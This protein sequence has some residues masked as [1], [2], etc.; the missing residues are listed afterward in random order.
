MY[1]S[2]LLALLLASVAAAVP[3]ASAQIP[4]QPVAQTAQVYE[5]LGVSVAGTEDEN[6]RRF[7]LQVSGL[8]VG[9]QVQLP[10]DDSV[11]E[12]V[13]KLYQ[14]GSFSNIEV[15]AENIVGNGI[16]LLIRVE[17]QPRLGS[18]RF[19]GIKRGQRD[20]LEDLVPLLR[21]RPVR[22]VDVAR[23]EQVIRNYFRDEGYLLVDI[24]VEQSMGENGRAD[25]VYTIDRGRKV[26]VENIRFVGNEAF[27]DRTL[28]KRLKNTPENRWWRFWGGESFVAREFEDDLEALVNWYQDEGYYGARVVQD[29]VWVVGEEEG[30]PEVNIRINV[31]EGPQYVV[32]N[33]T[34]EGNTEYTDAQLRAALGFEKG[35]VYSKK[36]FEQN[37]YYNPDHSDVASL[38]TDRGYLR[39][40][41][42]PT[43]TEAPGDSLDMAFLINEGDVYEFGQITIAG[44]TKTKEH[45]IRREL[46]TIPGQTYSRQA[47]ERSVRELITLNYFA[48][49][50]LAGGPAI[51]ID[52]DSKT[53]GLTYKLTEA[54]GDQLELS[55]GWGGFTGLL[56]QAGVRFNN[57]SIQNIFNGSAWRP[58]PSGDGQTLALQVQT[59]GRFYQN[60]S[61]SFTEPWFRGRPNPVGFSLGYTYNGLRSRFVSSDL[62]E[63][64]SFQLFNARVF[65]RF[66]LKFPDDFFQTGTDLSYRLY[67]IRGD[68]FSRVFGLPTGISQELN[69]RQSLTRNSLNNPLFP[70]AGSSLLLSAEAALP[71]PGF[72]QYHKWRLSNDWYLPIFGRLSF[73]AKAD[74][75][76]IGSLTG[77]DVEFQRYLIGGSPL[78]AQGGGFVGFGKDVLFM[79]GYP[80]GVISPQQDGEAVGGR[81]FNQYSAEIQLLAVQSPQLQFAPYV[82]LDAANTWDRFATYN[83]S[84]L[85][86]SAG[87]GAKLFLPI[88]GLVD[89]NYGYQIDPFTP[90]SN[91]SETGVPQ[92]RFQF[93][94][95]GQ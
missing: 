42:F 54:G 46:R 1:R 13:R 71:L 60:Y 62:E 77:D 53:V 37:L 59:N 21:G 88:L 74:Y 23:T 16:F 80:F 20:D 44:N 65:N 3:P 83:P 24:D 26:E 70:S 55:G 45:V 76:Y 72:I 52:E 75:G 51:D 47:I 87:F 28:R 48:Q 4:A 81:I 63:G 73:G 22:P 66:R 18:I 9:Q 32:R 19:E 68:D 8:E 10:V 43:I 79:R 34:F 67:N 2:A 30:D 41:A 36:K 90:R 15:V 49:E 84:K 69:I 17:E 94:L 64:D 12:A 78:D 85:F 35:E 29:S 61:I 40:N 31:E 25:L 82:F 6:T 14:A 27:S 58:V 95:G 89:L 7:V 11:A 93:S 5:I 91:S 92:W 33:V 56:L 57:F 86:R 38:Y 50:E 39:F